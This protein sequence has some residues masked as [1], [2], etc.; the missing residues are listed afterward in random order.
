MPSDTRIIKLKGLLMNPKIQPTLYDTK[1]KPTWTVDL[2]LDKE[3]LKIAKSEKLIVKKSRVNKADGSVKTPY[4]GLFD[5]Y[6]GSFIR[7]PRGV[8][9]AKGL[10]REPPKVIDAKLNPFPPNIKIGNG[11]KANCQFIVKNKNESDIKEYGGFGTFLLGVQILKLVEYQSNTPQDPNVDFVEE[12]GD[13]IAPK[14]F[15]FT[16]GDD[17]DDIFDEPTKA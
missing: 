16:K 13:S 11:T 1:Y 8:K 17:L 9:D 12:D 2:L 6:D 4:A 3:N 10:D 5:G 14:P 7:L 15:D